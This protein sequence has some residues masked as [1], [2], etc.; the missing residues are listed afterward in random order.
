MEE[1]KLSSV[2][3][4]WWLPN[5]SSLLVTVFLIPREDKLKRVTYRSGFQIL[6]TLSISVSNQI[7]LGEHN[8]KKKGEGN[9]A[10]LN[11]KLEKLIVHPNFDHINLINDIILL[12]LAQE[13]D[14]ATYP[15]A[16][17]PTAD[18]ST[19]YDG[20]MALAVGNFIFRLGR[21]KFEIIIEGS[22]V[23]LR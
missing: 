22:R 21:S 15:P 12:Y 3:E 11:I 17:L 1:D 9:L 4:L 16:C 20:K 6:T 5:T 7:T 8:R 19:A 18:D 2:V 13:V 14:L 23:M 10:E